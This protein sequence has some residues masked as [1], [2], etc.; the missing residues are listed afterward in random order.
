MEYGRIDKDELSEY[1]SYRRDYRILLIDE[2]KDLFVDTYSNGHKITAWGTI[3]CIIEACLA[4][5]DPDER[6]LVMSLIE[7]SFSIVGSEKYEDE[8]DFFSVCCKK[9]GF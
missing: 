4:Y 1:F 2:M 7:D 8:E 9:D 6:G 5:S 3:T